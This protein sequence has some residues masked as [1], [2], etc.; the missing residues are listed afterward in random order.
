MLRSLHSRL[1][2]SFIILIGI[3]ECIL[4]TS[5]TIYLLRNPSSL[6]QANLHIEVA[7]NLI[8]RGQKVFGF[9]PTEQ[10]PQSAQRI[11]ENLKVRL[12][13]YSDAGDLLVDTRSQSEPA[14]LITRNIIDIPVLRLSDRRT[15]RDT[16]NNI[17]LYT[18]RKLDNGFYLIVA[19]P[20]PKLTIL[21]LIRDEVFTPFF[22]AGLIAL[23]LSVF[24]AY[25]ISQWISKPLQ[26]IASAAQNI[27][28][29]KYT[30]ITTKGPEEVEKVAIAFNEMTTRVEISKES[31]KNFIANVSHDLKTPLTSIQGYAQAILDDTAVSPDQIKQSAQVIYQESE[32]MNRMVQDLL[33]LARLDSGIT[34][35]TQ[36]PVDLSAL[37]HEAIQRFSFHAE[38]AGISLSS[39]IS[40]RLQIIGD[41]DRLMQVFS[42]LLDNAVKFTATGGNII[43]QAS[44][45]QGY[46]QITVSDTGIGIPPEAQAYI[47]DRFY[48]V[49]KSRT[50]NEHIGVGLGLSIAREIILAHKGTIDVYNNEDSPHSYQTPQ[51]YPGTTFVIKLPLTSPVDTPNMSKKKRS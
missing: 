48:Q 15:A 4:A 20:R 12:L 6:R 27:A 51:P 34:P 49:E 39:E 21:Q 24:F 9:L 47:F 41:S 1:W 29:G 10:I 31:Q 37:L 28:S 36:E 45:F 7:A 32:R 19:T 25:G 23:I 22:T 38:K 17:W 11:D 16:D 33:E 2:L 30:K 13:I 14:L 8:Q 43:L 42:N 26:R 18:V 3:V 44:L 50:S 40:P 35:F 5:L 46:I